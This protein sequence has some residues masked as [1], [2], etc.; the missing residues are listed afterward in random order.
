MVGNPKSLDEL[1]RR[2]FDLGLKCRRCRRYLVMNAEQAHAQ[3]V[4]RRRPTVWEALPHQFRC[5]GCGAK[6]VEVLPVYRW[7][8]IGRRPP[9]IEAL[10]TFATHDKSEGVTHIRIFCRTCPESTVPVE[11]FPPH[12]PIAHAWKHARCEHCGANAIASQPE[13]PN[14]LR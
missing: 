13:W 7:Q 9:P 3:L 12:L 5:Q 11:A 8:G 1:I 4:A 6:D 14:P 2:S 10:P